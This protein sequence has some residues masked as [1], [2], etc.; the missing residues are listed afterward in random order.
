VRVTVITQLLVCATSLTCVTIGGPQLSV[1][2]PPPKFGA[3]RLAMHSTVAAGG[4]ITNGGVVS[5]RVMVW[6]QVA[7]LVHWSVALHVR[8]I[9]LA[10]RSFAQLLPEVSTSLCVIVTG[11][12]RA[13]AAAVP[14]AAGL[15]SLPHSTVTF[16][17]QVR[18]GGTP[19]GRL[20]VMVCVQVAMF[21]AQSIA[22][23]VRITTML[24]PQGP[25]DT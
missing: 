9:V 17:G 4:Q 16:A 10:M 5:R 24:G 11:P 3:G 18:A 20:T 14:V 13:A 15:V 12:Q 7:T 1:A 21:P 25:P 8:S 22:V 23:Q 19:S 2:V 6:T